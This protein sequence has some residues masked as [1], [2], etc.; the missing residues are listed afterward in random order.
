LEIVTASGLVEL[1]V[2]WPELSLV[3]LAGLELAWW[4]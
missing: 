2:P 4:S 3:E 1:A